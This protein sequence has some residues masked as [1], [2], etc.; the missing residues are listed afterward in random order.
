MSP[1]TNKR[2]IVSKRPLGGN[3]KNI[4]LM[5]SELALEVSSHGSE[6][7]SEVV[8]AATVSKTQKDRSEKRFSSR[9]S[10][11][12]ANTR[13]VFKN[14]D[15][16][17]DAGDGPSM[18]INSATIKVAVCKQQRRTIIKWLAGS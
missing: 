11:D 8:F 15:D 18:G 3:P 2:P 13:D 17:I 1:T 14:G 6:Y 7:V 10:F 5:S 16:A 9:K 4:T 12:N